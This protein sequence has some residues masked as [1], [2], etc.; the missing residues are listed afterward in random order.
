MV[1]DRIISSVLCEIYFNESALTIILPSTYIDGNPHDF[2]EKGFDVQG[3]GR[4]DPHAFR[5]VGGAFM[6]SAADGGG[7]LSA[8]PDVSKLQPLMNARAR[9]GSKGSQVSGLSSDVD[10]GEMDDDGLG[11]TPFFSEGKAP[12]EESVDAVDAAAVPDQPPVQSAQSSWQNNSKGLAMLS[13]LRQGNAGNAV[14]KQQIVQPLSTTSTSNPSKQE[15]KNSIDKNINKKTHSAKKL[16]GPRRGVGAYIQFLI[17][18]KSRVLVAS[19]EYT[20]WRLTNGRIAKKGTEGTSWLWA[21]DFDERTATS[22]NQPKPILDVFMTDREI[23][24]KSQQEKLSILPPL[25]GSSHQTHSSAS[26]KTPIQQPEPRLAYNTQHSN[27]NLT[28]MKQWVQQL[29]KS[30]PTKEFGDFRL[31]VTAIMNSMAAVE[32]QA[33]R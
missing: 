10:G 14:E 5:V 15:K 11:L 28:W 32:T 12:W 27:L 8:P 23:T 16:W 3:E 7:V 17:N 18:E 31:D 20:A 2:A 30:Q 9:A 19:E 22:S 24:A 26:T 21:H 29:P 33:T 4:V 25:T 1:R 13:K 6:N